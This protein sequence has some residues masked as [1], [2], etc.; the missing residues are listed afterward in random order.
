[1]LDITNG[2]VPSNLSVLPVLPP[3]MKPG[4]LTE[5]EKKLAA[6]LY[7]IAG[8]NYRAIN[9]DPKVIRQIIGVNN[10]GDLTFPRPPATMTGPFIVQHRLRFWAPDGQQLFADYAVNM[11]SADPAHPA[12]PH[13]PQ[14]TP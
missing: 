14:V 9:R 13:Y 7:Q 2:G 3:P 5:E 4:E 1:Y 8:N 12:D 10:M 6:S 11:E